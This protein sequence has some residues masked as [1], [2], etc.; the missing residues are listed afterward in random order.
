MSGG[1]E[2]RINRRSSNFDRACFMV[3]QPNEDGVMGRDK[4]ER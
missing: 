3:G 2:I 1:L 4:Q